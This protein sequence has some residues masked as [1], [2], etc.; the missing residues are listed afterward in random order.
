MIMTIA[1]TLCS[2][3]MRALLIRSE[4]RLWRLRRG[5]MPLATLA[6][7]PVESVPSFHSCGVYSS[8]HMDGAVV[9]PASALIWPSEAFW[10]QIVKTRKPL[11]AAMPGATFW[12][13]KEYGS[14]DTSAVAAWFY[15]LNLYTDRFK[16]VQQSSLEY[17]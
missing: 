5:G 11:W 8:A 17:Q 4:F 14:V 2:G 13:K 6:V 15:L 9:V 7:S 3:D 12:R 1:C 10:T 16:V